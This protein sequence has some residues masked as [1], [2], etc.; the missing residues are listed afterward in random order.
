[1]PQRKSE[2]TIRESNPGQL[3]GRQLCYHYT[4]GAIPEVT[5]VINHH[6]P[7]KLGTNQGSNLVFL[8]TIFA[9]IIIF[10]YCSIIP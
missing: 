3:L 4:N 10:E 8:N 1:M 9:F 2:C 6:N 5:S 7:T